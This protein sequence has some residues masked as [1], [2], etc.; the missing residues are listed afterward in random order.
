[1]LM[2]LVPQ[3]QAQVPRAED[4]VQSKRQRQK[5]IA[6]IDL[7]GSILCFWRSSQSR[8]RKW[9]QMQLWESA[10]NTLLYC[11]RRLGLGCKSEGLFHEQKWSGHF[12]AARRS[13]RGGEALGVAFT[14][15][16]HSGGWAAL[17]IA[18]PASPCHPPGATRGAE[19]LGSARLVTL[20]TRSARLQL[21]AEVQ[22]LKHRWPLGM[23]TECESGCELCDD[24]CLA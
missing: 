19:S 1:M 17:A 14:A 16:I 24:M 21:L 12:C 10:R 20:H 3:N 18:D 11:P 9:K 6:A 15:L 8:T 2:P 13:I 7:R 5:G 22:P 23:G 4:D